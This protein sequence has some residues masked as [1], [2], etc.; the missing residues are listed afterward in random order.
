MTTPVDALGRRLCAK[1]SFVDLS[2]G[3]NMEDF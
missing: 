2:L 1:L 3:A